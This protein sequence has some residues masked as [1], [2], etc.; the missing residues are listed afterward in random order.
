MRRREFH[1]CMSDAPFAHL[2]REHAESALG[3]TNTDCIVTRGVRHPHDR[4]PGVATAPDGAGGRPLA[5]HRHL[6][7]DCELPAGLPETLL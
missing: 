7:R 3:P 5:L 4:A 6:V 2:T 1:A